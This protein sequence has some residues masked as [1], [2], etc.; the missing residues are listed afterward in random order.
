MFLFRHPREDGD[1][2]IINKM[3]YTIHSLEQTKE[4]A[5]TITLGLRDREFFVVLFYGTLA[6][7]K[8]TTIQMIGKELGINE[9]MQSPTYATIRSYPLELPA[10]VLHHMDLYRA[11]SFEDI[12]SLGVLDLFHEKKGLFFIEWPEYLE[13]F[14]EKYVP[15]GRVLHVKIE[16]EGDMRKVNISTNKI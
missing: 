15:K 11:G 12:A 13:E 4:L 3:Q 8:T 16:L 10:E 14:L 1:P 5:E 9:P 7:G 6:S 2:S